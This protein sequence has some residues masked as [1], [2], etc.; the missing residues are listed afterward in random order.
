MA[1]ELTIWCNAKFP[2]EQFE[3][4]RAGLG[5]HRLVQPPATEVSNLKPGAPDPSMDAADIAYGQPNAEQAMRVS[6]LK[7][8]QLNS[9][10]YTR[11]DARDFRD[12]MTRNGTI[13]CN[14]SSVY[15]EPCAQHALAMM[16]AFAR[17][18]PQARDN[19]RGPRGWPYLELRGQSHLLNGQTA[20]LVGYGAIARR[21]AQL[22][23]PFEMNLIGF[24]RRPTGD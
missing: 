9:A 21:L 8:I 16:L 13:V 17:R 23:A 22:L 5:R 12:A 18:L 3:R 4:L 6:R 2:P 20:L 11:Y 14:A 1:A 10:G 24:K 7:W 15:A 19:Q